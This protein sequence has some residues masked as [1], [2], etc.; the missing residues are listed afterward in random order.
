MSVEIDGDILPPSTIN[1]LDIFML[2]VLR[3]R[4]NPETF[5]MVEKESEIDYSIDR[6]IIR[7]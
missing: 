2:N 6:K 5:D 1:K 3:F 7:S 4:S